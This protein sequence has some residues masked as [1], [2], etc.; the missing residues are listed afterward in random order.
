MI[1][2]KRTGG[3]RT[4]WVRN[5][6]TTPYLSYPALEEVEGLIHGISTRLGGVSQGHLSSLNLSYARGDQAQNVSENFTRIASS[7]GFA[8]TSMVFSHQTHTT[9]VRVVTKADRGNGF[10][11]PLPYHDVDGLVTNAA[12]LTLTTF[13][14]D[15][16]PLFLIDPVKK[17]IGLSHSGWRGTVGK[18]G[19]VT[20]ETMQEQFDCNPEQMIAAIGPSI[21]QGCY[22][23]SSD[24]AEVFTKSYD[25]E[26]WDDILSL[27]QSPAGTTGVPLSGGQKYQLNLWKANELVFLEAGIK[28]EHIYVTDICTCCNPELLYSHRASAGRRGNLAAFLGL[29]E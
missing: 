27:R 16:V 13:Y 28:K 2:I 14:A 20:V 8:V 21:C 17:V 22:E 26:Y 9:N 18:I 19:R 25:R 7:I 6:D 24:V 3:K 1:K 12:G 5:E 15:C 11:R 29:K 10:D 23:V 4:L